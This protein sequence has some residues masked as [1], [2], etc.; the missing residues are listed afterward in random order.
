LPD[1]QTTAAASLS[2]FTIARAA[3]IAVAFDPASW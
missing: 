1:D 2:F 3:L